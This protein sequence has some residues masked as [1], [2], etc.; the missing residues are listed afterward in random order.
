VWWLQTLPVLR[1][2]YS[3]IEAVYSRI[4]KRNI[5]LARQEL[6]LPDRRELDEAVMDILGLP[7]S[8]IDDLYETVQTMIANRIHKARRELTKT[9]GHE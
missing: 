7:R 1:D 2:R 4:R 5:E 8:S 3:D 9:S 6:S